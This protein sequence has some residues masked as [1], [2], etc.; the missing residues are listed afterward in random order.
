MRVWERNEGPEED[1]NSTG[2]ITESTNLNL[3]GCPE[4]EPS[5]KKYT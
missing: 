4:T 3:W 2:R 1:K 5:T